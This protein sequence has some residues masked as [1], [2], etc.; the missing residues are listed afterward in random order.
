[1]TEHVD[2][3]SLETYTYKFGALQ[4]LDGKSSYIFFFMSLQ[5]TG[6][7]NFHFQDNDVVFK[8]ILSSLRRRFI[9]ISL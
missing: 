9:A 8:N 7:F 1:M 4:S 3:V 6:N 2:F 5:S